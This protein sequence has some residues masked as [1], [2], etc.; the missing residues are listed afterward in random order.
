MRRRVVVVHPNWSVGALAKS[1]N[2]VVLWTAVAGPPTPQAIWHL[3]THITVV[4]NP[5]TALVTGCCI[6]PALLNA[7]PV[8]AFHVVW[9]RVINAK[10]PINVSHVLPAGQVLPWSV[11]VGLSIAFGLCDRDATKRRPRLAAELNLWRWSPLHQMSRTGFFVV[12]FHP[13]R[14][15]RADIAGFQHVQVLP[16]RPVCWTR[17]VRRRLFWRSKVLLP[18]PCTSKLAGTL[19]LALLHRCLVSLGLGRVFPFPRNWVVLVLLLRV[20]QLGVDAHVV[21]RS[22]VSA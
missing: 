5:A 9:K 7:A 11:P 3:A 14:S 16:R 20:V 13:A 22:A 2:P 8:P 19:G 18:A 21:G 15:L 4:Y 6:G 1:W 10:A 17:R 12:D